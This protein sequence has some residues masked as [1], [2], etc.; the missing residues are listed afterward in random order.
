MRVL[1]VEDDPLLADG[2]AQL[3][4]GSG[5]PGLRRHALCA[6]VGGG[7]KA[8]GCA[9]DAVLADGALCGLHVHRGK[10]RASGARG[11]IGASEPD[12]ETG[13]R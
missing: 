9:T 8:V 11:Q 3:L 10:R 13:I 12:D 7:G 2:V 6:G 4:R 5:L 1:I